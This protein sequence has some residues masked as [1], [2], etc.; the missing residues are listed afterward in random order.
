VSGGSPSLLRQLAAVERAATNL[1]GHVQ[2]LRSLVEKGKRPELELKIAEQWL[3]DLQA[4]A[5]TLQILIKPH[6]QKKTGE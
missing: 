3:P 1:G 4:A 2:N 5:R 6:L